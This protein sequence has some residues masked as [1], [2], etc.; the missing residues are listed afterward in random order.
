[1]SIFSNETR[2]KLGDD[3]K[4]I[5]VSLSEGNPGA[6]NVIIQII[7]ESERID[8]DAAMGPF[9][10]LLNLDSYNIYGSKIWILYKDI[11]GSSILNTI[12]VL[13]AVQLGLLEGHML[14]RAIDSIEN[15]NEHEKVVI[16]VDKILKDVQERLPNFAKV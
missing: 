10:H 15:F 9:A 3:F 8:P 11:S 14:I 2:I 7:K 13:R 16:A 5:A 6:L 12:A 4:S 1:M